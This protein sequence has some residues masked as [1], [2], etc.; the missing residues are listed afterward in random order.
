MSISD[1]NFGEWCPIDELKTSI[2]KHIS[3]EDI[4]CEE[5]NREYNDDAKKFYDEILPIF[6]YA[7]ECDASEV[8]YVDDST[9][10]N[11]FDGKIK[12]D[13]EVIN[14]EC[15]KAIS[16]DDA[17]LQ[18]KIDEEC[19]KVGYS[20]LPGISMPVNNFRE[21]ITQCIQYAVEK[22]IEK[23]QKQERKYKGFHLILTL[24]DTSFKFANKH[25]IHH[26]IN[27]YW[28]L[29]NIAPFKKIVLYWKTNTGYPEKIKEID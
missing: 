10:E 28:T 22:K 23:S 6:H 18:R 26:G 13:D 5:N 17:V 4:H 27:S 11:S 16:Q 9:R 7:K 15:T 12:V 19:Y 20:M 2:D 25:D 3:I 14:I 8:Y 29:T 21:N 1:I 24:D